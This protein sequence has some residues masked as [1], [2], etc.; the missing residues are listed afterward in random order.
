MQ[1]KLVFIFMFLTSCAYNG[2]PSDITIISVDQSGAGQGKIEFCSDFSLDK[3][4]A[5]A[6]FE[7]AEI[8]TAVK[9]H[10]EYSYLPCF[11]KGKCLRKNA[12]CS[13]EIRAGGTAY[14]AFDGETIIYGCKS[15]SEQLMG[16]N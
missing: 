14:L 9:M 16:G 5:Q 12:P 10:D 2:G 3:I 11:V 13:W 7:Q 8:I 15:C 1:V 4:S 6:F